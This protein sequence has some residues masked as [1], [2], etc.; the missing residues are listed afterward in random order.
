MFPETVS[1]LTDYI[2]DRFPEIDG[3]CTLCVRAFWRG[4]NNVAMLK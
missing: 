2:H 4:L 3:D 1:E